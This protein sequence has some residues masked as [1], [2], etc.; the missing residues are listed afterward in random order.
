MYP[1]TPELGSGTPGTWGLGGEP[2]SWS[3]ARAPEDPSPCPPPTHTQAQRGPPALPPFSHTHSRSQGPLKE[4]PTAGTQ[5]H[6]PPLS[7]E[8][9]PVA[10]LPPSEL[11]RSLGLP[12]I[13][14]HFF[15]FSKVVF[16]GDKWGDPTVGP[17]PSTGPP[18]F[19]FAGLHE[20][21]V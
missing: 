18:P 7:P 14:S 2:G 6:R 3:R 5:G 19:F 17:L 9:R 1:R 20:W 13:F 8:A 16:W 12:F 10:P 15:F 11:P 4:H 21:K